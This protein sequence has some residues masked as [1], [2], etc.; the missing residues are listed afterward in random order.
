MRFP[1]ADKRVLLVCS[2]GRGSGTIRIELKTGGIWKFE[3]LVEA[4]GKT[5]QEE[6]FF[7]WKPG[8]D[9]VLIS[10]PRRE[11][12]ETGQRASRDLQD[13]LSLLF[14]NMYSE[15]PWREDLIGIFLLRVYLRNDYGRPIGVQFSRWENHQ[16]SGDSKAITMFKKLRGLRV[17]DSPAERIPGPGRFGAEKILVATNQAFS[18][19]VEVQHVDKVKHT[20]GVLED[21]QPLGAF[22][23]SIEGKQVCLPITYGQIKQPDVPDY[24]PRQRSPEK[25]T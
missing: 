17:E 12:S 10:D 18:V 3:F 4:Q 8:E 14:V 13:H 19:N 11:R 6:Y 7:S 15:L 22:S 1:Y 21:E 24:P 9:P 25:V 16:L 20:G 2:E 23:L 5:R